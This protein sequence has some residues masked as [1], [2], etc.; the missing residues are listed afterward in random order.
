MTKHILLIQGAGAGAY[1]VDKQL[2]TSL[3]HSLDPQDAIVPF[4]HLAL[5]AQ[6]LPEATV[7]ERDEGGHQFNNDLSFVAEDIKSLH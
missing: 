6:I 7:C 1:E 3:L 5:Y 2:A 4:D